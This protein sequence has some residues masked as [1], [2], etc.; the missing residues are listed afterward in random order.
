MRDDDARQQRLRERAHRLVEHVVDPE[1]T[2]ISFS[3]GSMWMSL[4]RS[5][6]A[7]CSSESTRRM[8][9]AS[10]SESSRSCGSAADLAGER[11]RN[12]RAASLDDVEGAASAPAIVDLVDRGHD[13]AAARQLGLDLGAVEEQAQVVEARGLERV[14]HGDPHGAVRRGRAA[15]ARGSWR[16]RSGCAR[17]SVLV[18]RRPALRVVRRVS[19]S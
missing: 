14:R 2:R 15:R 9:G 3:N 5:F 16:T 17:T 11:E 10:S 7:C 19:P 18:D 1:A 8:I 4:A 12:R 6:T 13:R